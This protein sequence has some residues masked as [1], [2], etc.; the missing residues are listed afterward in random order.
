MADWMFR[1]AGLFKPLYDRPHEV[2][3]QQPV[4]DGDETTIK[5]LKEDKSYMWLYCCGTNSSAPEAASP[6][7]PVRLSK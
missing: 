4:L 7:R 2:L 6:T 1:C 3:L 5:V